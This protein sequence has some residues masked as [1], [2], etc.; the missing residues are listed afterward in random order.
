MNFTTEELQKDV[1]IKFRYVE[2]SHRGVSRQL[3]TKRFAIGFPNH[4]APLLVVRRGFDPPSVPHPLQGGGSTAPTRRSYTMVCSTHQRV[5]I[6]PTQH[7]CDCLCSLRSLW[8]NQFLSLWE[9]KA[10]LS[11]SLWETKQTHPSPAGRQSKLI[12]LH[13]GEVR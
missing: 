7:S 3:L 12:P 4:P 11:L 5:G 9:D 1:N 10:N 8:R 13:L 2:T 6:V